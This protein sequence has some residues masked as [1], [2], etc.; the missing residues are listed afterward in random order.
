MYVLVSFQVVQ[1]FP[2]SAS[3]P[4]G[5][6]IL[7]LDVQATGAPTHD[8]IFAYHVLYLVLDLPTV[9]H[10]PRLP[11]HRE[12]KLEALLPS[13]RLPRPPALPHAH[14]PTG[15]PETAGVAPWPSEV[16]S[17]DVG[18]VGVG[19]GGGSGFPMGSIV[20]MLLAWITTP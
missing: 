17:G 15:P 4:G 10:Y 5:L 12:E 13:G 11:V 14:V 1:I 3:L 16:W 6:H 19:E 7:F 9:E 2:C 18:L 20:S 8:M